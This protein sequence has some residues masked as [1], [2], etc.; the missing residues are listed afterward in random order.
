MKHITSTLFNSFFEDC[1]DT[2]VQLHIHAFENMD[3]YTDAVN[4]EGTAMETEYLDSLGYHNDFVPTN[5]PL[6]SK[7]SS[8]GFK[9]IGSFLVVI[10]ILTIVI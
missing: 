4:I 8:Y 6:G 1:A 10:E 9:V 5:P 7:Y 3:E 2:A